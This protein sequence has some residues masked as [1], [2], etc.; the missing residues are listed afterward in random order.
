MPVADKEVSGGDRVFGL[1][2]MVSCV[3]CRC[4]MSSCTYKRLSLGRSN[5]VIAPSLQLDDKMVPDTPG[6]CS[7]GALFEN[8][9][10]RVECA[11]GDVVGCTLVVTEPL[12]DSGG[13][14]KPPGG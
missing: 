1:Y 6:K 10:G 11:Y 4:S 13:L 9:L 2:H 8:G 7:V 12:I 5:V 14:R 3:F